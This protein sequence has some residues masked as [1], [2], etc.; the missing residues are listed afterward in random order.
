MPNLELALSALHIHTYTHIH[1]HIR[2]TCLTHI[3]TEVRV[4]TE[5]SEHTKDID[6]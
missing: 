6:I 5:E 3:D 4:N 2:L 1:A